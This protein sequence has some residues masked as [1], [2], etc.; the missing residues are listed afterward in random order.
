MPQLPRPS[1][2]ITQEWALLGLPEFPLVH[3]APVTHGCQSSFDNVPFIDSLA[4]SFLHAVTDISWGQLH[5]KP[6]T[7]KN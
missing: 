2:E 6:L 3:F 4:V 5:N 1:E 7:L